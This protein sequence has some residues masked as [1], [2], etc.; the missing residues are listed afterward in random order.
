M[1]IRSRPHR[2]HLRPVRLG[3][4]LAQKVADRIRDRILTADFQHG[5]RLVEAQ[6]AR[7][8][9]VSRGPVREALRQLRAEG[10][11]RDEPRHGTFVVALNAD[12]VREI[13]DLR[14]ALEAGAVRILISNGTDLDFKELDEALDR[15]SEAARRGDAE[16]VSR[17]DLAFHETLCRLTGN[18]R[19]HQAFVGQAALVRTLIEAEEERYYES[20]Q[21][22]WREHRPL[23]SAIRA[24]DSRLAEDLCYEHLERSKTHLIDL[25]RRLTSSKGV[26]LQEVAVEMT[27]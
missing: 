11:V 22:V 10:L 18:G 12:D 24:R 4:T 1:T 21:D 14:A 20:L 23:L 9:G 16:A 5:Q 26:G 13:Y 2:T 6:L 19:L 3:P 27:E 7:D 17:F 15:I 25:S 8:L